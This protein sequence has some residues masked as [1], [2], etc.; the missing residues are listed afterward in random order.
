MKKAL[1]TGINGM[2]GSHM[3]DLLLSKGY[4]VFGLERHKT[5]IDRRNIDHI[6]D[7]ITIIKGDLSD[8]GSIY[9]ILGESNPDEV[10][11]FA[12][13]SFVGDSWALPEHTGNITGLGVLRMLEAIK[14]FNPKIRFLQAST[15]EMFG[16]LESDIANE[17]SRFYPRNPY[18]VA[19]I[20]GHHTVQNYR[21]SYDMFACSSI[22]FNHECLFQNT[23]VIIKKNEDIDIVYVS[24]LVNGRKDISKDTA[25]DTKNY[26]G[27]EY[28]VWDGT[29]F[30]ELKA[31]SRR[32]LNNLKN[33][34]DRVRQ[35]TIAPSAA[36]STTPNHTIIKDGKNN[37][38]ARE[39]IEGTELIIGEYP[40]LNNTK[41]V[42][43]EYAKFLGL[44]AGDGY[45]NDQEV[46]LTN[47]DSEISTLFVRLA[48][49]IYTGIYSRKSTHTS[50]FGGTTTHTSLRNI[51]KSQC[52]V[53][54]DSLYESRIK[55]KK[56]PAIILNGSVEVQKAFLDGYYLADGLKKDK[57]A[58]EF[59]SFKTNSPLL[60]QGLLYLIANTIKV[61]ECINVF[62]QNE[63]LYYQVNFRSPG[64]PHNSGAHL[65][66]PHNVVKK[67]I[68]HQEKNQH[69]YDI[70]TGSGVIMAGVGKCIIGNSERRGMQFV[71]RKITNA[72]AAI[73]L[74][75]QTHISL[76]SLT[77]RRD[78]GYAPDYVEAIYKM[79]QLDTPQDLVLATG[80]SH[81]V[82]DFVREAFKIVGID[83]WQDYIVEDPK[84][85]RPVEVDFLRGDA[86]RAKKLLDWDI[87]VEFP[88]IVKRMVNNDIKLLGGPHE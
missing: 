19:K 50:G 68:I 16:K 20:F 86:S 44:L 4:E 35:V 49:N 45:V 74:G 8:I 43:I 1:I 75:L 69:V 79:L 48:K 23:P 52:E 22:S 29:N 13:Q 60:A 14:N 30:V 71:T 37:K 87:T 53:L 81:S 54:R 12:A 64:N 24:S 42:T 56:V 18:A 17:D 80:V 41:S 55:H 15:S 21:E 31:V 66:K 3:A 82:K 34:E 61:E 59:K 26:E 73:N 57:T 65:K 51:S 5:A 76:G 38:T 40:Q 46:S 63:K 47:N 77:P 7:D 9:R 85:M 39:A 70:E 28:E 11:N 10:Y 88:E 6:I 84:F 36:V 62:E 33:T 27:E 32:K 78:W 2:D 25:T 83:N 72:V 67:R 58:Y